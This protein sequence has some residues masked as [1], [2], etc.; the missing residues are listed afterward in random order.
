MSDLAELDRRALH[1]A[2]KVVD[3]VT[4][5]QLSLPTPCSAWDLG[6]LLAHMTGQNHGFAAA[7]RGERTD[8]S[9][10]VDRPVGAEP[11]KVFAA[12]AAEIV[13]AFADAGALEREWW[14]PEVR[15]GQSFPGAEAMGFHFVDYVVHA[16]DVAAAIG[17][18]VEFDADLLTAV[19]PIAEAVPGGTARTRPGAS[20]APALSLD[21]PDE[22]ATLDQ[23]LRVLGRSPNWPK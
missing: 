11:G 15:G 9:A 4:V 5:D 19:L 2:Q 21:R 6:Q 7:A 22:P 13:A 10:W 14:L 1:V 18:T 23:V 20:F 3:R 16:W 17:V 8:S 12:S